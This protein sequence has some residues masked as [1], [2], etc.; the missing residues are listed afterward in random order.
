[1]NPP[2]FDEAC[3]LLEYEEMKGLFR[4]HVSSD[5]G[6]GALATL[7]PTGDETEIRSRLELR[8]EVA[9]VLDKGSRIPLGGC[10]DLSPLLTNVRD[11]GRPL[12]PEE[13]GSVAET[14]ECARNLVV[15]IEAARI[16][17]GAV[18]AGAAG[19]LR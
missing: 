10:H 2:S 19:F 15:A 7:A 3:R 16:P 14:L 12:E 9:A 18:L 6:R 8:G 1:M 4:P 17:A 5:L 11:R 13:L